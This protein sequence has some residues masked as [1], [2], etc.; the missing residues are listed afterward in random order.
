MPRSLY[1]QSTGIRRRGAPDT[2]PAVSQELVILP[3]HGSANYDITE[4]SGIALENFTHV[5]IHL[6]GLTR[7][8]DTGHFDMQLSTNG[9]STFLGGTNY[10]Y[11][12]TS[13][14]NHDPQQ[15]SVFRLTTLAGMTTYRGTVWL[16]SLNQP[17]PTGFRSTSLATGE[18]NP[19][20]WAGQTVFAQVHNAIRFVTGG[21]N[22]D[23]GTITITGYRCRVGTLYT[24]T[25]TG[26]ASVDFTLAKGEFIADHFVTNVATSTASVIYIR[27]GVGDTY[28]TTNYNRGSMDSIA[29][30]VT[31]GGNG[32]FFNINNAASAGRYSFGTIYNM[33]TAAPIV[34]Q[35][36]ELD[37]DGV[38]TTPQELRSF[39]LDGTTSYNQI[40]VIASAGT[41]DSGTVYI[42]TY[43]PKQTIHMALDLSV[44]PAADRNDV[45]G[46]TEKNASLLV[47]ATADALRTAAGD[48][49]YCRVGVSGVQATN[50]TQ[51]QLDEAQ[52]VIAAATIM[53]LTDTGSRAEAGSLSTI[54]G[55]PHP[56]NTQMI[57]TQSL[58]PNS[59]TT[60]EVRGVVRDTAVVEDFLS[61]QQ[62][63]AE[64][65]LSGN[66]YIVGY[67]L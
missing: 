31:H 57:F 43:K 40:R 51:L 14:V 38:D 62:N 50:Y 7:T 10:R 26:E 58:S 35:G 8:V 36:I 9:G 13:S 32:I 25:F 2:L 16:S 24:H 22:W 44:G 30:V 5:Q 60:M 67:S 39:I 29:S 33:Q 23:G 4:I 56:T 46:L 42:Q 63:G 1:L 17:V 12:Q 19:A 48:Q 59:A 3:G 20:H 53:R 52:N 55:L 61:Y 47:V 54:V 11:Q 28:P 41:I 64:T 27:P 6:S 45:T 65:W 66:V 18:T 34:A 49:T 37:P 21:G 15:T